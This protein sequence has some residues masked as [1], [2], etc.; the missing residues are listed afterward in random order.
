MKNLSI[1]TKLLSFGGILVVVLLVVIAFSYIATQS[2]RDRLDQAFNQNF[3]AVSTIGNL[4]ADLNAARAELVSLIAS[5]DRDAQL[6]HQRVIDEMTERSRADFDRLREM[7]ADDPQAMRHLED[8]YEAWSAFQQTRDNELI[9]LALEGEQD[10]ARELA[11]GIQRERYELFRDEIANLVEQQGGVFGQLVD[12]ADREGST[13]QSAMFA[14]IIVTAGVVA[15]SVYFVGRLTRP[16]TDLAL[17]ASEIAKGDVNQKITYESGDELGV[18]AQ[19]FRDMITYVQEVANAAERLSEGDT[20]VAVQIR[21]DADVLSKSFTTM[22]AYIQ[23]IADAANRLGEGDLTATV[24]PR[25]DKDLLSRNFNKAIEGLQEMSQRTKDAV[26]SITSSTNESMAGVNQLTSSS[27][28]QSAA[29]SETSST[30]EELRQS[31]EEVA[32]R[33]KNVSN[34]AKEAQSAAEEGQAIIEQTVEGM[35]KISERIEQIARSILSL[36][37]QTQAV[38]K[39]TSSVNDIAEQSK[40]LAFN[41]SIEAAKAGEFGK[42][43]AVVATEIRNLAEQ[44]KAATGQ[45]SEILS[46]IQKAANQ[47]VMVT[48]E[49]SKEAERGMD[50]ANTSG[51]KIRSIGEAIRNTAQTAVQIESATTQQARGMDQIAKAMGNVNEATNQALASSKQMERAMQDLTALADQLNSSVA[52]YR[53]Q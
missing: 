19:S 45:I 21:S 24:T 12:D 16:I 27:Q 26:S 41:A 5:E 13:L 9:P 48:E 36:S 17:A 49:G 42:G 31:G 33:T 18:L 52:A 30:V 7:L 35:R 22:L 44:S 23:G 6:Q 34:V 43:F 46:D 4:N 1:R 25:S 29:V 39:I 38:G 15:L 20:D 32:E 53:L 8:A 3:A 37:E 11:L 47:S 2:T 51:E 50:L 28:Q 10:G 14:I 40:M